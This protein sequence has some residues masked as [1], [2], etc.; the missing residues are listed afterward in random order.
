MRNWIVVA[1]GLVSAIVSTREAAAC[2]VHAVASPGGRLVAQVFC[3]RAG[4]LAW[5]ATWDGRDVASGLLGLDVFL[6]GDLG[7]DPQVR[8]VA[9]TQGGAS[10]AVRGAHAFA[11]VSWNELQLELRH[12]D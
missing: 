11:D 9:F 2:D 1:T 4:H 8:A 3:D 10:F 12:R 7:S 5:S 6:H